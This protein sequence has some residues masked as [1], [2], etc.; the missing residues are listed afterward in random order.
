MLSSLSALS[1]SLAVVVNI[2]VI[3]VLWLDNIMLGS[4][5]AGI[6]QLSSLFSLWSSFSYL[7]RYFWSLTLGS[8]FWFYLSTF[9]L[10][11]IMS[12][13]GNNN[14][15]SDYF[16][17]VHFSITFLSI[18]VNLPFLWFPFVY[19]F[20]ICDAKGDIILYY[21]YLRQPFSFATW[22]THVFSISFWVSFTWL[23][24]LFVP[25]LHSS[26]FVGRYNT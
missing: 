23:Q 5:T 21:A 3:C 11:I 4:Y 17:N 14:S 22:F 26:C 19:N 15:D 7:Y 12:S 20:M 1:S 2:A 6:L 8:Q 13:I 10:G 25:N 9:L 16:C 24:V 18:L